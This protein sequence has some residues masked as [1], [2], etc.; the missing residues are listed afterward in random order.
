MLLSVIIV[1]YNSKGLLENCL[2]SVQNAMKE[3]DGEI[4]V[5]DNNSSDGSKEYL[6]QKFADV[7]FIFNGL[8][9]TK[10]RVFL[11]I[12]LIFSRGQP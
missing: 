5:V 3:L 9:L 10:V 1:S 6:P 11:K 4:I 7:K 2:F 8:P 12:I